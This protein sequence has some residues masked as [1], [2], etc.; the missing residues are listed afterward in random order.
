VYSLL[1][2]VNQRIGKICIILCHKYIDMIR[3]SIALLILALTALGISCSSS[4]ISEEPQSTSQEP[5][6][7]SHA[8]QELYEKGVDRHLGTIK[9]NSSVITG[10]GVTQHLFSGID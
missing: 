10:L 1:T 8:F 4:D 3:T 6:S 2:F 5:S 9:P 7:G